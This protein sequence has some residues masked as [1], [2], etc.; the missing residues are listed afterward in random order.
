MEWPKVDLEAFR[1]VPAGQRAALVGLTIA[2]LLTGFYYLDWQG[3][4][5]QEEQLRQK[6]E[7]LDKEMQGLMLEVKHLDELVAANKQL[8]LELETKKAKLPPESEAVTLLKQLSETGTRLGL[9][10]RL[11]KPGPQTEDPRKLY[12]RMPVSVEVAGGYHTA[13]LFFDRI[14]KMER[15]VNVS[16][17]K[18]GGAK[19]E[20]DRVVI[21]T[22]FE[23]TAFASHPDGATP[24][25]PAK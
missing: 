2:G 25:A 11:W 1:G 16:D 5:A 17:L 10:I 4:R 8:E 3:K 21:Q 18:M 22:T 12:V 20:G 24:Q 19:R 23:L 6:V 9:E 7:A 13:A 15:I 14:G